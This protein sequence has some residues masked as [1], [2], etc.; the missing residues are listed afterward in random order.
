[1]HSAPELSTEV[2]VLDIEHQTRLAW[3]TYGKHHLERATPL[4]EVERISWGPAANGPGDA[5]LGDV[6]GLR[7][8]DIGCG[9]GRHAAHLARTYGAQVDGV[10]ASLRGLLETECGAGGSVRACCSGDCG[11]AGA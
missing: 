2:D 9:P 4:P 10:D 5:L 8:L 11:R 7:V 1:M 6:E 3:D